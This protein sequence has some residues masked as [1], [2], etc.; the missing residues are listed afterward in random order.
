MVK[1]VEDLQRVGG[2]TAMRV[3]PK[4]ASQLHQLLTARDPD[5]LVHEGKE[6]AGD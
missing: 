4:A 6:G 2:R 3:G 1:E 5:M